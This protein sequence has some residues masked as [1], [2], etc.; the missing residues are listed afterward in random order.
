MYTKSEMG[1][2]ILALALPIYDLQE[3][4]MVGIL[5]MELFPS[6]IFR[7]LTYN[8]YFKIKD[9]FLI[10]SKGNVAYTNNV[11]L[12]NRFLS[13]KQ[14]DSLMNMGSHVM[15]TSEGRFVVSNSNANGLYGVLY[16]PNESIRSYQLAST[17][18]MTLTMVMATVAILIL[19][20]QLVKKLSR[21]FD[22]LVYKLDHLDLS[23]APDQ[24][25]SAAP[26]EGRD[27]IALVTS[28]SPISS[29]AFNSWF[30]KTTFSRPWPGRP[31]SGRLP[32]RSTP[33]SCITRWKP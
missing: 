21:R 19:G 28:T 9:I 14:F 30:R 16:L 17:I 22:L 6:R 31:S 5:K 23:K 4:E 12:S 24:W 8:D 13:N 25:N 32:P 3:Q 26:I 20:L 15:T 29:S 1:Y 18:R 7:V 10:D 33:I 11:A 27:E 2:Q